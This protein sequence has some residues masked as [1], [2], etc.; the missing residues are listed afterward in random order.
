MHPTALWGS[1]TWNDTLVPARCSR[2]IS[3]GSLC[4]AWEP[5][6]SCMEWR[7]D[8]TVGTLL[9]L[10]PLV[11]KSWHKYMQGIQ[12]WVLKWHRVSTP[13]LRKYLL[14][15]SYK[16]GSED[17]RTHTSDHNNPR[18]AKTSMPVPSSCLP[19]T[20]HMRPSWTMPSA[21]ED[22]GS[23]CG[24]ERKCLFLSR[25]LLCTL[26][27]LLILYTADTQCIHIGC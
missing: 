7:E 12:S 19:P 24:W 23:E 10:P 18:F 14:H 25:F 6:K 15:S 9:L 8:E 16:R 17:R 22:S 2:E 27:S 21:Q 3:T 1:E 26:F 13:T 20:C 11:T 5:V 4:A